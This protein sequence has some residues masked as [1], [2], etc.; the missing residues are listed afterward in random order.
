MGPSSKRSQT[1]RSSRELRRDPTPVDPSSPSR[2]AKRRK[3]GGGSGGGGDPPSQDIPND[4]SSSIVADV[5]PA[6]TN[7][8]QI[9]SQVAQHLTVARDQPPKASQDHSNAIH[10]TNKEGVKAY[11][12]IAAHDWTFYVTN[13]A[14]NIGRHHDQA[15]L[16]NEDDQIHIDLSPN[17]MVSRQHARISFDPKTETWNILVKGRNGVR[18]NSRLVK[19]H[20]SHGLSSGEVIEVGL[21]EMMFVLPS[22]ISPLKISPPYLQR[23]GIP[24]ATAATSSSAPPSSA[25]KDRE[26]APSINNDTKPQRHHH[27]HHHQHQNPSLPP[28]STLQSAVQESPSKA[29]SVRSQQQQSGGKVPLAPA[30]ADYKRPG[31]PPSSAKGRISTSQ[32]RS[33]HNVGSGTMMMTQSD[34]DLSLDENKHIKPPYSYSQ[35]IT[36]A[37]T[38]AEDQ[39]LNLSGIYAY[40]M[41]RY[42]YYRTAPVGGWQNSIRHNLSLNK[43]FEKV[44]RTTDEPGKGM[45][46]HIVGE[47]YD[48]M[49][50]NAYRGGRGGHRGSSAPS[51]PNNFGHPSQAQRDMAGVRE[52]TPAR[53][54]KLSNP[55]SPPQSSNLPSQF[56]P[57][58]SSRFLNPSHNTMADGSPLPRPRKPLASA[59]PSSENPPRSPTLT[60]SY[61]PEDNFVTP[62]PQRLHPRLAPPSTAQRPSQ[63][64]PTSSP[65]PF[66]KYADIGSTPLKP[67]QFD[68]SP[69]KPGTGPPV[70]SSSPPPA[71][72][73]RSPVVSPTRGIGKDKRDSTEDEITLFTVHDPHAH[74]VSVS[75]PTP[76]KDSQD[77]DEG[78]FDLTK[79]FQ[80]IGSY[81]TPA[82]HGAPIGATPRGL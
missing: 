50:R 82:G 2:P 1:S 13:L 75:R 31:T 5:N 62:A 77:G 30:P 64:M 81:H 58:R 21:N 34:V 60:S 27:R 54:R 6:N 52:P 3:K 68:L 72:S 73:D 36:Q 12:K 43:A 66:W 70:H 4:D 67:A 35:L 23:A 74:S 17:K 15:D 40:I 48:E 49:V 46:W 28:P 47:Q 39:K 56:T 29:R 51:S 79:G 22:E 41:D 80:S 18:V 11:A 61:N 10:E 24:T 38:R 26:P 7:D 57:D 78:S 25:A 9:V 14:V 44:A 20:E 71:T 69:S 76:S 59:I 63:H 16:D 65:A 55:G 19:Q 37:I 42:A 53:K 33:P 8:D 45:K 32:L